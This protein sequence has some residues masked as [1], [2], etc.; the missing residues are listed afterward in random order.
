MS[1]ESVEQVEQRIRDIV[2]SP[3]RS[4]HLRQDAT[5]WH[6]LCASLDAI[7]DT[8]L[9]VRAYLD[10][11]RG[12]TVHDGW[13]YLIVHGVLQVLYVQQDAARTLSRSLKMEWKLPDEL[14][15]VRDVRNLAIGHPTTANG[16]A[17]TISRPSLSTAGFMMLVYPKDGGRPE[18]KGVGIA[19]LVQRQM[20]EMAALLGRVLERLVEDEREHRRAFQNRRL[21]D[22][23]PVGYMVEKVGEGLRDAN[24]QAFAVAGLQ[25]IQRTIAA[26][27]EAMEERGIVECY[28]DSVGS[29]LNELA[30]V[31]DRI[32]RRLDGHLPEW[33]DGDVEV[34]RYYLQ[35]K[36]DELREVLE[37]IDE[38]YASDNAS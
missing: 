21:A 24:A 30:L 5:A 25:S 17:V 34:Y 32:G 27:R 4:S 26:T 19:D 18:F 3:R 16:G 1:E 7:G 22:L 31:I 10:E 38:D 14:D 15:A 29:T 8:Q 36:L 35:A 6:Q 37:E 11:P 9:A 20:A 33:E 28:A 12:D 23:G 13:A 2:S